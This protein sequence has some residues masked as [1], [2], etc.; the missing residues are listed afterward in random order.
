MRAERKGDA[1]LGP[2]PEPFYV[3]PH[4]RL[5]SCVPCL[6]DAF[7]KVAHECSAREFT[8]ASHLSMLGNIGGQH[9]K[10]KVE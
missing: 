1:Q 7:L 10:A 2:L 5:F 6:P 4:A 3:L 9:N 8:Q